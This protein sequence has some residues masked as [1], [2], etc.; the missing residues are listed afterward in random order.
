MAQIFQMS[1]R[2]RRFNAFLVRL[3]RRG[4]AFGPFYLLT[5]RRRRTGQLQEIP[6]SPIIH[7]DRWWLVAP[8]GVGD[9]VRNVR[10]AGQVMVM[11][12]RSH[13]AFRVRELPPAESAPILK[14][15]VG[16]FV[17]AR[18]YFDAK[19]QSPVEAFQA[20]A[21]AHPVFEL[22]PAPASAERV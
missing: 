17:I 12:G 10:A 15:Y 22:I 9:W 2:Q 13:R 5:V 11:R 21:P 1:E 16:R 7:G 6:V 4:L 8:Y 18:P 14:E 20:E 3:M 19:P